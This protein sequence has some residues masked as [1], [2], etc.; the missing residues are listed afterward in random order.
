MWGQRRRSRPAQLA[1]QLDWEGHPQPL[2]VAGQR[3]EARPLRSNN[4]ERAVFSRF[5][6][7][8]RAWVADDKIEARV[9]ARGAVRELHVHLR[10]PPL[11]ELERLG[12]QRGP[13]VSVLVKG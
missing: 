6:G 4:E 13:V 7:F 8:L 5:D 11:A 3:G 12:A 9:A 10:S 2:I 1:E